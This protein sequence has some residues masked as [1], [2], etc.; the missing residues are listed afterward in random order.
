[1]TDK[2]VHSSSEE[3]RLRNV[4]AQVWRVCVQ[5]EDIRFVGRRDKGDKNPLFIYAGFSSLEAARAFWDQSGQKFVPTGVHHGL[6]H[7]D[8]G[9]T[10]EPVELCAPH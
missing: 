6:G 8:W 2:S 3:E 5:A 9:Q 4:M 10:S 7:V 1:M